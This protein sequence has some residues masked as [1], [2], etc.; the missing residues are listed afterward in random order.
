M[1]RS[2]LA[3]SIALRADLRSLRQRARLRLAD[4]AAQSGVSVSLLKQ[5]ERGIVAPSV[6][7]LKQIATLLG[8]DAAELAEI[9]AHL[10]LKGV[11]GEGYVTA[12]PG[13]RSIVERSVAPRDNTIRVLDLFCGSGGFSFGFERCKQFAVTAGIDLLQDRA[14]TYSDN[15]P[16]AATVTA[17]I[18]TF[19]VDELSR[20]AL[21]PAVIIGGPPCQGFS[22][23]RPFRDRGRG[24]S[25]NNL[26]EEFALIVEAIR[27]EWFVL[28]NVV[29]LLTHDKGATL[30]ALLDTFA[31]IGFVVDWRVLNA[32]HYGLP[33]TRERLVVVGNRRARRF[34][35]PVPTHSVDHRSMAGSRAQ[36]VYAEPLFHPNLRP[37]I[38]LMEGIGDLPPLRAGEAV[39]EYDESAPLSEYAAR[40]RGS[41]KRL[42]MHDA[43]AHS[44]KMLEIIRHAGTNRSALPEGMTSSG[45]SSCYSRL[46]PDRPSVTLTVNFVHPSSNRCIHPFQDRALTPR[47]GARLQGFPDSFTFSG[48]RSQVV[49]QIGN[50]VPPLLGE[51]IARAIADQW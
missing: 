36:R 7:D 43:T 9:Q 12:Q 5:W 2:S 10:A 4:L 50:A 41:E 34:A 13:D 47:E 11:R 23:I 29:G 48:T 17:D 37:A 26:F 14:R 24:D 1:S 30:N 31:Q 6:D 18:R 44:P 27:P 42:T 28:E 19:D 22:S 15:H 25:R 46:E 16:A 49:K 39:H 33:Q 32:A 21:G 40:L 8:Y 38:T 51:T 3:E 35:W 45:F 20:L